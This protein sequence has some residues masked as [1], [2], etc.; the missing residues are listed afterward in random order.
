MNVHHERTMILYFMSKYDLLFE[1]VMLIL[2]EENELS[3]AEYSLIFLENDQIKLFYPGRSN[4]SSISRNVPL[5]SLFNHALHWLRS[6][7]NQ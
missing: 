7:F 4:L 3:Q 2:G 1:S 6:I 5:E